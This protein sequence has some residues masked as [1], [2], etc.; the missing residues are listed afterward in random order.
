MHT[1]EIESSADRESGSQHD[2]KTDK[3]T[4]KEAV[5]PG[6]RK[7]EKMSDKKIYIV[8][9][10]LH[11]DCQVQ[12]MVYHCMATTAKEASEI[13]KRNW[14]RKE[15]MF[16]VHAVR[17]RINDQRLLT[18]RTWK[19]R[20]IKGEDVMNHAHMTNFHTWR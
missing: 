2:R 20:E 15:H 3:K 12:N 16:H 6:R 1:H 5:N 18:V 17:S 7:D 8:T 14:T 4:N 19:G 9:F 13:A 11:K 10:E